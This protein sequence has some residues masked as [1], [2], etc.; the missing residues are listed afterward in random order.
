MRTIIVLIA[1]L[2]IT[3]CIH[4][5]TCIQNNYY[6]AECTVDIN[7]VVVQYSSPVEQPEWF[8][9]NICNNLRKA[10]TGIK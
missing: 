3:G 7:I 1:S 10:T 6:S 9:R 2:C 5:S 4:G 8:V